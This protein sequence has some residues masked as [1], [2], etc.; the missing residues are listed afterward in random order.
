MP[1]SP[2]V[3]AV[4]RGLVF[5]NHD[6]ASRSC[7]CPA[8]LAE[9][10]FCPRPLREDPAQLRPYKCLEYFEAMPAADQQNYVS[11]AEDTPRTILLLSIKEI[12]LQLAF[13]NEQCFL[14]VEYFARTG[15]CV[16]APMTLP[17]A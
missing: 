16:C 1:P 10:W 7:T 11:G 5:R 17:G 2:V 9:S 14:R 15:L 13:T 6:R 12:D 4:Q 3:I 8:K